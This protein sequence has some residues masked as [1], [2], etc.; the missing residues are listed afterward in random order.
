MKAWTKESALEKGYPWE[1]VKLCVEKIEDALALLALV[2]EADHCQRHL[3]ANDV[4]AS[5]FTASE[6]LSGALRD[7]CEV[8]ARQLSMEGEMPLSWESLSPWGRHR[9]ATMEESD[10]FLRRCESHGVQLRILDNCLPYVRPP[11][12]RRR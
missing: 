10:S 1:V 2:E 7:W 9:D 6:N 3:H 5:V 11:R 12:G 8:L 4:P